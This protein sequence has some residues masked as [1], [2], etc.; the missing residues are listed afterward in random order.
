MRQSTA[1][2]QVKCQECNALLKQ[3]ARGCIKCGTRITDNNI[4]KT[5][6]N[7]L[8]IR[9]AVNRLR[10][11]E[12]FKSRSLDASLTDAAVES[13]GNA[14]SFV[15]VG[16]ISAKGTQKRQASIS[17]DVVIDNPQLML[18]GLVVEATNQGGEPESQAKNEDEPSPALGSDYEKLRRLFRAS[19]NT[20]EIEDPR[21]KASNQLDYARRLTYLFLYANELERRTR[22]PRAD[23]NAILDDAGVNDSV[24]CPNSPGICGHQYGQIDSNLGHMR[25]QPENFTL[26]PTGEIGSLGKAPLR[27]P[28]VRCE[29]PRGRHESAQRREIPLGVHPGRV[30]LDSFKS[31]L[32]SSRFCLSMGRRPA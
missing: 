27:A 23:L 8:T 21:L 16:R 18:P 19:G 2:N 14:L 13:L 11:D 6:T 28:L 17:E 15:L 3:S 32:V 30:N 25:R 12:T 4:H 22:V 5:A 31:G 9:P 24:R 7:G 10:F 20:L 1:P 26:P 29:F